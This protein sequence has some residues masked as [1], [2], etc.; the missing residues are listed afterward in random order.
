MARAGLR[1]SR[2]EIWT[3]IPVELRVSAPVTR[4]DEM[5][6]LQVVLPVL[7]MCTGKL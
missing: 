6:E 4:D 3:A 5:T 1:E 2:K 7:K